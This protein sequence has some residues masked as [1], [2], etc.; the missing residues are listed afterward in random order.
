M[1]PPLLFVAYKDLGGR[2]QVKGYVPHFSNDG[3]DGFRW[4]NIGGAVSEGA[5]DSISLDVLN[6]TL[7]VA[8]KDYT[9]GGK[10]TVK[11]YQFPAPLS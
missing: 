6:Y 11:K 8:F 10:V 4:K 2:V 9:N 1:A 3:F 5:A 7:F